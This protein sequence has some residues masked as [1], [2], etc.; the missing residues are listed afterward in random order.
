[1]SKKYNKFKLAGI[2]LLLL[3]FTTVKPDSARAAEKLELNRSYT[4]QLEDNDD[5]RL[6]EFTV[7]EAGNIIIQVKNANPVGNQEVS[8]QLYDSNN[9]ALTE[10]RSGTNIEL[11][12]YSTDGDHTFYIKLDSYFNVNNTSYYLSAGFQPTTDWETEKNDTTAEADLVTPGRS[13]YGSI[14][15]GHDECDYF[16]FE[17]DS[18][19]KVDITFGPKEISGENYEWSVDLI[20]ENNQSV[21]IYIDSTT[22]TY[23]CYLKKGAYYLK[24]KNYFHAGNIPYA[25]SY[26]ETDLKL[27]KPVIK[28]FSV[29]KSTS[30][31][32][33]KEVDLDRVKIKNTGDAEGYVVKVS[34]KKN[35]KKPYK[36][37][38][39]HFDG[40]NTK[41]HVS[42][43]THFSAAKSYYMQAKS[44]VEDPFG[45]K[46][47]GKYG[48][49]KGKI[50]KNSVYNNLK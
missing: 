31:W 37:E 32:S 24:V 5:S 34:N 23:T 1:M 26:K 18:A 29:V 22:R 10:K 15:D 39:I 13:W 38:D 35:M 7:P 40:G 50:L 17:L 6:Y 49:V 16:K 47:Y 20:D 25:L 30:I 45:V 41:S 48:N 3:L 19:K 36:T 8:V 21:N 43:K 33:N 27:E 2:F 9:L 28:S 14:V 46:I 4:V 44:Y 42:L 12:V 11:P